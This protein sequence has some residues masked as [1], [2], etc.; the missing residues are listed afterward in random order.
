M[1]RPDILAAEHRLKAANANI[2]A[3]RAAFFPHHADR[4]L[5]TASTEL[6]GLFGAGSGVWSFSQSV[7]LPIFDGGR[8]WANLDVSEARRNLAVADY[9]RTIQRAFRE[10]A[11]ALTERHWLT[12]QIVNQQATLRLKRNGHVWPGCVIKTVRRRTLRSSMPNATGFWPNRR[13]YR[14]D[15]HCWRAV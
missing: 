12:E 5:G 3:A 9:E 7:T 1:N 13:W 6:S 2:G 8:N 15:G 4:R 14:Y 11:D 10:V